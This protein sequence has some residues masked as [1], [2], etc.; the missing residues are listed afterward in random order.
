MIL[1]GDKVEITGIEAEDQEFMNAL[2]ND[3]DI[4]HMTA[5]ECF[6]VSMHD[7]TAWFAEHGGDRDPLRMAVRDKTSSNIIGMIYIDTINYKNQSC[8]TGIKLGGAHFTD[9]VKW[10]SK[11]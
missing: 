5:G 10:L 8:S 2:I 11:C 3:P 7:Q 9:A 4:E 1:L 6:P